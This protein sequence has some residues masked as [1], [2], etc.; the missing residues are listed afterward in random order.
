MGRRQRQRQ[1]ARI[2]GLSCISFDIYT[3]LTEEHLKEMEALN[4]R[5]PFE[6]EEERQGKD[7]LEAREPD[8]T[9]STLPHHAHKE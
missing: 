9:P 7:L 5:S 6:F 4:P 3:S 1:R 2:P 8:K